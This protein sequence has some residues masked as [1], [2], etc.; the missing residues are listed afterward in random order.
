MIQRILVT[1]G[2]WILIICILV[3]VS[4]R[5]ALIFEWVPENFSPSGV[6]HQQYIEFKEN[7]L[8]DSMTDDNYGHAALILL[9]TLAR[10]ERYV[11]ERKIIADEQANISEECKSNSIMR[12]FM[13]LGKDSG[14]NK[15]CTPKRLE[16]KK[17]RQERKVAP[18]DSTT[19]NVDPPVSTSTPVSTD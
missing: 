4:Y 8:Q 9:K 3:F 5:V 15:Q 7:L 2:Q 17:D 1:T 14:A 11:A 18:I 6:I 12:Y 13:F 16:I 10:S 19:I